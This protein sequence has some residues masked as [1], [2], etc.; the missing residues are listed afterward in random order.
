[1]FVNCDPTLLAPEQIVPATA[2]F[3]SISGILWSEN[4]SNWT[5]G[6]LLK[7]TQLAL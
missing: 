2:Q 6:S 3:M 1:M 5:E 4:Y 7:P